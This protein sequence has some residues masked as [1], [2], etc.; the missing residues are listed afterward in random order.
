MNHFYWIVAILLVVLVLTLPQEGAPAASPSITPSV[1]TNPIKH[2]VVLMM[3]NHAY[4]NYFGTYCL[5]KGPYC[6][7]KGIGVPMGTCISEINAANLTNHCVKT[8]PEPWS[9]V[10]TSI[11]GGHDWKTAHKDWNNG[12][13]NNFYAGQGFTNTTF[14]EY[15]GTTLPLYWDLAEQYSLADRFFSSTMTYSLP[16]HW[17]LI[18]GQSPSIVEGDTPWLAP[19]VSIVAD[20]EYLNESNATPTIVDELLQH[21]SVTWKYYDWPLLNYTTAISMMNAKDGSAYNFWNPLAAKAED[22]YNRTSAHFVDQDSFF[23]DSKKGT[24]PDISWIIPNQYSDHPPANL[25]RGEAFITSVVDAVESSPDW[26]STALFISWD[27]F[28]AEYDN[29]APP[30]VDG[31]GYGFR[32]PMILVS[33]YARENFISSKFDLS[34]DSLLRYEEL[35]FG[36]G[37]LTPRDCDASLPT[38]MLNI[39]APPRAP[40]LF[41]TN[42]KSWVYPMPLEAQTAPWTPLSFTPSPYALNTTFNPDTDQD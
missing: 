32:V 4:D 5:K 14:A 18:A 8:Y 33:P 39:T 1:H 30:A 11:G 17:Y 21:P 9:A 24:L 12:L 38:N 26:N 25:S 28:G 23:N 22:Y 7:N 13:M 16:N 31:Y 37:C 29:V 6:S 35:T 3:E 20:H 19:S 41:S 15:D 40:M 36:L 34:F 10:F 27:D 42:W 2:I